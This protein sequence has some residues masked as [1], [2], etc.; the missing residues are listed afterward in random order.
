MSVCPGC[1]RAVELPAEGEDAAC[2]VCGHVFTID[3]PPPPDVPALATAI[4]YPF[5][6][7]GA[8]IFLAITVPLYAVCRAV[9]IYPF[10][11]FGQLILGGYIAQW[12][13]EILAS[14]AQG[15]HEAPGAPLSGHLHELIGNFFRFFGAFAVAFGPAALLSSVLWWNDVPRESP[16]AAVSA[17]LALAGLFYYPMALLL[18]GFSERWSAALHLP[19]ALRS[20][21]SI[22]RDYLLCCVF[23]LVTFGVSTA[24]ETGVAALPSDLHFLLHFG[25]RLAAGVVEVALYAIQMRAVG[26]VYLANRDRLGWFRY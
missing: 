9:P 7:P 11:L 23:F 21:W 20:I 2:A 24:I 4:R 25:A 12:L 6:T 13:W 22:R 5:S 1:D 18:I 16:L 26:L 3:V 8:R 10:N 17:L 14:T 19:F 15:R